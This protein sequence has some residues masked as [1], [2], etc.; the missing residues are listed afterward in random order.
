[1]PSELLSV[2]AVLRT[3]PELI[4]NEPAAP[5]TAVFMVTDEGG[6]VGVEFTWME[7][8]ILLV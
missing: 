2:A 7:R 8:D 5:I 1:M 6:G 3:P 4:L